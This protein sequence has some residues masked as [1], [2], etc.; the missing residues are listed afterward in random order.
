MFIPDPGGLLMNKKRKCGILAHISSLPTGYGVGDFGPTAEHFIHL[1]K[2][3]GIG[4]WQILPL[5]PTENIM[6]HSPYSSYSAFAL[7]TLFISPEI[8]KKYC[9][10]LWKGSEGHAQS[11]GP[12]TIC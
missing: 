10:A 9:Q 4:Y 6:G 11:T 1:L 7:N 8:L 2:K 3:T 5:N 12:I